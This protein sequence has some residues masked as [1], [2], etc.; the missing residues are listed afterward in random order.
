[1]AVAVILLMT[2]SVGICKAGQEADGKTW[3]ENKM[4]VHT[5]IQNVVSRFYTAVDKRDWGGATSLM[6]DPFHLDYSSF[7][8]GEPADLNPEVIINGWKSI[9][10]GFEHTHHQLGNIDIVVEG[11]FAVVRCYVTAT[12]VIGDQVWTVVGRY[13]NTLVVEDAVWK[14]SGSRFIFKYQTGAID[15]PQMAQSLVAESN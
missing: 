5:E 15:L 1:M 14:L 11:D 13:H 8:G 3:V 4:E 6:T 12:H 2:V 9:L 7:G 10:P